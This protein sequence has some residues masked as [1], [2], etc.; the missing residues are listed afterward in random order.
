MAFVPM[1]EGVKLPRQVGVKVMALAFGLGS[2]D[3]AD[4]ALQALRVGQLAQFSVVPQEQHEI[5]R[6]NLR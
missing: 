5:R 4:G 3:D 6:A 2:V 1:Q